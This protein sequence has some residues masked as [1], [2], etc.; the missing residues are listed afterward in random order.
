MP[1]SQLAWHMVSV[2]STCIDNIRR[3]FKVVDQITF[4]EH[5]NNS[6]QSTFSTKLNIFMLFIFFHFVIVKWCIIML[7]FFFF[8]SCLFLLCIPRGQNN[9]PQS[10]LAVIRYIFVE[11][12]NEVQDSVCLI[13]RMVMSMP[14]P[15]TL[16]KLKLNGS[17]NTYKTFQN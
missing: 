12:I 10:Q 8:A 7:F 11:W 4:P 6:S 17:V 14:K 2:S 13:K 16:K 1:K 9:F 15:V 3:S 5:C